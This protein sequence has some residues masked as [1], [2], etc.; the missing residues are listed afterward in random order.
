MRFSILIPHYVTGKMT[1]YCIHQ[2]QKCKGSHDIDIIVIDNSNGIG[3]EYIKPEPNVIIVSYP[4]KLIQSHGLAFDFVLEHIPT[5]SEY[6]ITLE[7]DAFPTQD[8]WLDYY[9]QLINEGYDMAGSLMKLSGGE[10]IHPAGAMYKKS[11]WKEA[12]ELVKQYNETIDFYPNFAVKDETMFDYHVM[13][14]N[15]IAVR[16]N[17][18][19]APKYDPQEKLSEYLPI[20]QS[21]FHN[22]QGFNQESFTTYGQRTIEGEKGTI[23]IPARRPEPI[24]YRMGYEPGQWFTYWHYATGKKVKQIPTEIHWM[25]NRRN[26]QQ[27]YTRMEN[28]LTH[29]WGVSAYAGSTEQDTKDISDFKNNQMETLYASI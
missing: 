10:Y 16:D 3:T 17:F 18:R 13:V 5:I 9:E 12:K 1:A 14:Y 11:N 15:K 28:G 8:N 23:L 25:E 29:L 26:Q 21:V 4:P 19:V 20:A 22:G 6:F 24:I 27:E 2:L 7:S